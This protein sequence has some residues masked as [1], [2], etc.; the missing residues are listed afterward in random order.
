MKDLQN[1]YWEKYK[2]VLEDIKGLNK[3]LKYHAHGSGHW[4]S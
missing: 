3:I 2:T 1:L 4:L